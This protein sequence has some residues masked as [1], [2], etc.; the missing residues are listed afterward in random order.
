MC[1]KVNTTD[2]IME[3]PPHWT[4]KAIQEF[5]T[6]VPANPG[7]VGA[8]VMAQ[9]R[10]TGRFIDNVRVALGGTRILEAAF[11]TAAIFDADLIPETPLIYQKRP[12]DIIIRTNLNSS[13]WADVRDLLQ[14]REIL[15]ARPGVEEDDNEDLLTLLDGLEGPTANQAAIRWAVC[16]GDDQRLQLVLQALPG[17]A[18]VL[19][20]KRAL[21][22]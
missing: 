16:V 1:R 8:E 17:S 6:A 5:A 20:S 22:G 14:E 12:A 4:V 9:A 10:V 15:A 21:K 18:T 7:E 19:N 2:S 11:S 13:E 3:F